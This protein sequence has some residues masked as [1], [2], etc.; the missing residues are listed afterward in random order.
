MPDCRLSTLEQRVLG[1]W[2]EGDVPGSV[3]PS[4]YFDFLRRR[5]AGPLAGVFRHNRD[6]VLSLI[7]LLGWLAHALAH[8][9]HGVDDAFDLVGVARLWER[10]DP[11]R[12]VACY[13]A[14]LA[15]GLPTGAAHQVRLR[16]ASWEKRWSRWDAACT[17]W[18]EA[19]AA[20]SFDPRPRSEERR[21]G[22]ECRL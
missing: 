15:V 18:K 7:A 11:E 3:I 14:A 16:L 13:R 22:K 8:G 9:E 17:L 19:T 21:V 6:D 5:H 2:R 10:V 12:A 20:T 4:L 1:H